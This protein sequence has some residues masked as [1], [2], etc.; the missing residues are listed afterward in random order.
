MKLR[1][2]N[3]LSLRG[4]FFGFF[5]TALWARMSSGFPEGLPRVVSASNSSFWTNSTPFTH[6]PTF[7]YLA[8]STSGTT[9]ISSLGA[10]SYGISSNFND[11]INKNPVPSNTSVGLNRDPA[12]IAASSPSGTV[13]HRHDGNS[14]F[15]SV[16]TSSPA[17]SLLS[18]RV[19][20][21]IIPTTRVAYSAWNGTQGQNFRY[22]NITN[23]FSNDTQTQRPALTKITHPSLINSTTT[24][25]STTSMIPCPTSYATNYSIAL[26]TFPGW[27]S[28]VEAEMWDREYVSY[29]DKCLQFYCTDSYYRAI[30][31]Y[32]GPFTEM[33]TYTQEWLDWSLTTNDGVVDFA[34]ATE[35]STIISTV[36]AGKFDLVKRK[37]P[38]CGQCT[39]RADTV[40]F[41]YWPET[42]M[43]TTLHNGT[44]ETMSATI[45]DDLGST[46]V[47]EAGFTF[48]SPSVYIAFD[49]LVAFDQCST[50]LGTPLAKTT[51]AFDI[52]EI[53]T[54]QPYEMTYCTGGSSMAGWEDFFWSTKA[55]VA[56]N[57]P[58]LVKNCTV[59]PWGD[60]FH[61]YD[62]HNELYAYYGQQNPCYPLIAIPD[63]IKSLQP[64][65]NHCTGLWD[66]F[67]DPPK[68]LTPGKYL[69]P[70]TLPSSSI[71]TTPPTPGQTIPNVPAQTAN[72]LV[73]TRGNSI[74]NVPTPVQNV[75][76]TILGN[77]PDGPIVFP[78]TDG[79]LITAILT[80]PSPISFKNHASQ[81]LDPFPFSDPGLIVPVR[82]GSPSN[83]GNNPH[84][85]LEPL[86]PLDPGNPVDPGNR[87]VTGVFTRSNGALILPVRPGDVTALP[88]PPLIL[89]L[90]GKV[91]TA[92]PSR[93]I[94]VS[95]QTLGPGRTITITGMSL[96]LNNG[97]ITT[98]SAKR[99]EMDMKGTY[100]VIGGT[101]TIEMT[102]AYTLPPVFGRNTII[103]VSE[104]TIVI[105]A[106][107]IVRLGTTILVFG[108]S[109]VVGG[110]TKTVSDGGVRV[111]DGTT[112]SL[113]VEGTRLWIGTRTITLITRISEGEGSSKGM[114]G[115][116]V[117]P[118]AVGT[119]VLA[120][121]TRYDSDTTEEEKTRSG[122]QQTATGLFVPEPSR[123]RRLKNDLEAWIWAWCVVMGIGWVEI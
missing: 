49:T 30:D 77:G 32:T 17:V 46:F 64:E 67:Y 85:P 36:V 88:T 89:T 56:I 70:T 107:G 4:S 28:K 63:R 102:P 25:P 21:P 109:F 112:I 35:V 39:L 99:I 74:P 94:V 76:S 69:V 52:S 93:N 7:T 5:I 16:T 65:W 22:P 62:P 120:S 73:P 92:N 27:C 116:T 118:A 57:L 1:S 81:P 72:P 12:T 68:Y 11:L 117:T 86:E 15:G 13:E 43:A 121:R 75:L 33:R 29:S 104:L 47:D 111:E 19:T 113:G 37:A 80:I 123:G 26:R 115:A 71:P 41:I 108:T 6:S 50:Y 9:P 14:S 34:W 20:S 106:E 45:T 91:I 122:T 3:G 78:V 84:D 110:V 97:D 2:G 53:S 114:K 54:I 66:G 42:A 55:T 51:I 79:P 38:C 48:T 10:V 87:P 105:D 119:I 103:K 44:I 59:Y 100:I 23:V 31:A 24:I 83:P 98:V 90:D 61:P 8:S 96:T 60:P 82:P 40:H 18:S 95:G 58:D 101:L